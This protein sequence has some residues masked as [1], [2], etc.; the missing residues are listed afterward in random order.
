V[1][2]RKNFRFPEE[3]CSA[4]GTDVFQIHVILEPTTEKR[5]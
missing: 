2:N 3:F 4:R 5:S 1:L